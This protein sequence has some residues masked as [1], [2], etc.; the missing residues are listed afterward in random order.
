[1][2]EYQANFYS[3]LGS[4]AL[5]S[6]QRIVPL[7]TAVLPVRSV[8]DFGCGLGAWLNVWHSAGIDIAGVD[9][10]YIDRNRL[11]IDPA[12]F[13]AAD[14]AAPIN[15]GR[16]FDLV[17]SLEVAEHLPASKARQFV[18][19]LTRH[20]SCVLF[21]A[22]VPGQG[23]ENHINEQ[24]LGYWRELF[25]D[26]GFVAIDYLRPLIRDDAKIEPWYRYNIMLYVS[27][28]RLPDLPESVRSHLVGETD[29]LDDYRPLA[30]RLRH[31]VLRQLPI[32]AV[33]RLSRLRAALAA[34]KAGTG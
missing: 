11:L 8:A 26:E 18:G 7:I 24:P 12:Y 1:M 2:Y 34:R 3:Y 28:D 6:A 33:N 13:H 16:R 21:S 19:T 25:R 4:F 5:R 31:A 14:L 17:Q 27:R 9:G 23:G 22:A 32:G 30:D 20:G 29:E 10:P 15:L